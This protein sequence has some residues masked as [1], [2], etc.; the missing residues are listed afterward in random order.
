MLAH[1]DFVEQAERARRRGPAAAP[2]PRRQAAG[3]QEHRRRL[4]G[5]ARRVP[6]RGRGRGRRDAPHP[7]RAPRAAR[8]RAHDASSARSA[9][10]SSSSPRPEFVVMFLGDEAWF[11]AAL[12]HDPSL[13]EAGVEAGVDPGLADDADRAPPHRRLRLAAGDGR[14]ERPQGEQARPR[15]LRAPRRLHRPLRRGRQVARAARSATTTTPSASF[16]TRVLVTARKFPELGVGGDELPEVPPVID[17]VAP[18]PLGGARRGRLRRRAP[19]PR[20]RGVADCRE[21]RERFAAP[22]GV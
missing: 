5:A 9:T 22:A 19:A 11:R 13:L 10:G 7:P 21:I 8:A 18:A 14:R 6:R 4:E 17:P 12:D 16:E 2:R 1:C 20:R 15:A 3:R